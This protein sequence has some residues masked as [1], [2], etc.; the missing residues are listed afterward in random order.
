MNGASAVDWEKLRAAAREARER[1][2]APY[3]SFRVGA[4]LLVSGRV[5]AGCNVENASYPVGICA[6]RAALAAAISTGCRDLQAVLVM[7]PTPI[8][9]CGMCRQALAEFNA[10]V[11]V[12][13][14]GADGGADIE[15]SIEEL[16]PRPFGPGISH[17]P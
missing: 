8:P 11:P 14:A 5:F 2:Y 6:E 17:D 1:A 16:L 9:P 10:K 7:G 15:T 4:A 3:S 12:L 13:L